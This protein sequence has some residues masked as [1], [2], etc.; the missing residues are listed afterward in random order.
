MGNG[1][2]L[3][4]QPTQAYVPLVTNL[5][6]RGKRMCYEVCWY[7]KMYYVLA[8]GESTR[9]RPHGHVYAWEFPISLQLIGWGCFSQPVAIIVIFMISTGGRR[10]RP[11]PLCCVHR[12][13]AVIPV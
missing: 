1:D 6:G 9:A 12:Q 11:A 3:H 13:A 10:F 7:R 8:I 2:T 4:V 5:L